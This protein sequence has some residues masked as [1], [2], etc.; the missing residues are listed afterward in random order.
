MNNLRKAQ[1][2]IDNLLIKKWKLDNQTK[3]L[4]FYWRTKSSWR[5]NIL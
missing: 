3:A 2:R 4:D 1:R 5:S